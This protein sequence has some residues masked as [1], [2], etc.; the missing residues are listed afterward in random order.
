M[1]TEPGAAAVFF[2]S[3]YGT[4]DEFVGVVHAVIHRLAPGVPVIDLCHQVPPFDVGAGADM[5]VRCAPSLGPGVVLAVVDP[6]VGTDRRAVALRT[7]GEGWH[8]SGPGWMVGPDNG[9][10]VAAAAWWGGISG[11]WSLGAPAGGRGQRATDGGEEARTFD[12]RDLFAPAAAHLALG[13]DPGAWGTPIDP[14]TLVGEAG[15]KSG[16]RASMGSERSTGHQGEEV[17][18]SAPVSWIDRFGN[19][20]LRLPAPR[21]EAIG[22]RVGDTATVSWSADGGGRTTEPDTVSVVAR[23]VEAFGQLGPGELGVMVDANGRVALVLDQRSAS[24]HIGVHDAGREM[25]IT[26]AHGGGR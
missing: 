19:I 15:G 23:R 8:R 9:L 22:L 2:L 25:T 20:Q 18:L 21:L 6:G 24:G 5:L 26:P 1:T 14:D 17:A 16:H 10:L 4:A 13:G 11:A 12:G 7:A 3:D